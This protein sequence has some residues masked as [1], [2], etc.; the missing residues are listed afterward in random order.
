MAKRFR[1]RLAPVLRYR[2][3]IEEEK[4]RDFA[5][6]NRAVEEERMR[7]EEMERERV[8]TQDAVREMYGKGGDFHRVVDAFRYMNGL[9]IEMMTTRRKMEAL[10]KIADEKRGVFVGARRDKRALEILKERQEEE[11][12]AEMGRE[13]QQQID[14]QG[15]RLRQRRGRDSG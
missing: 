12:K 13:E 5:K 11:A 10:Q 9:E 3:M 4:N 2:E 8:A 15:I 14:E 6:A 1:F 7:L